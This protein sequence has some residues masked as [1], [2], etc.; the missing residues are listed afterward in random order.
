MAT[1][2]VLRQR[3]PSVQESL[4]LQQ[5]RE[6][7]IWWGRPGGGASRARAGGAGAG[8]PRTLR[9]ETLSSQQLRKRAVRWG[10]PGGGACGATSGGPYESSLAGSAAGRR[11]GSGGRHPG[12]GGFRGTRTGGVEAPG[13]VEAASLG[14]FD[15]ASA[16]AEPEEALHTFTLDS[17]ASRC[18]FR[19]STTVTPLTAPVPVTLFG[20]RAWRYCSPVS[21]GPFRPPHRRWPRRG[22]LSGE[23]FDNA[24]RQPSVQES[25]LLQQLREWAIWWGRPGGGASRAR[26][27][28]AGA[29]GPRTRR[30]E[31]LSSQQL[32]KRAVRWGSPGGG[33]WGA[34]TGGPYE[35]TL[36]GSAA[37]R[38]GGSGGRHPGGGGFRGTRTGGVEA[39]GGVEAAS[40]GAFDSAS[41]GAEPEEA[42]HTFTLDSGASRCFFRESTTVTPLTAPVPV[43]L[44]GSRAW[45][46]CSPVSGG[47]FR[48]PHRSPPP[49]VR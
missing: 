2:T 12:G 18:F 4:L 7:A 30:Q 28:G 49:L 41:T 22:G 27:G 47:P 36:A 19:E 44:F 20:S 13:G 45:R 1:T 48:P 34:T 23:R 10:S 42:L 24:A 26:A 11:G 9:Q 35:S 38:R 31:T 16:G 37:G 3:Q 14:A 33:A 5:L 43:T 8:G 29:G 25:L 32:R 39:P 21:G 15:S 17:G 46:Y 40:L 6:W